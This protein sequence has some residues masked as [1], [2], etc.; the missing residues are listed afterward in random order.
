M[1]K[2]ES[3]IWVEDESKL[4][5]EENYDES[6]ALEFQKLLEDRESASSPGSL[7]SLSAGQLLTGTIVEITKD[8]VVVDVGLKSEGL[9]PSNEFASSDEIELGN[10]VE[11]YLDNTEAESGQILLSREKAR[12]QRQWEYILEK[13][14]SLKEK[15]LERS[16]VALW[17]TS[18]AWT[19][20]CLD[21][22]STTNESRQLMNTLARVSM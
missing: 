11:V 17:S 7:T 20:S 19:H 15:S 14:Q 10:Q 1:S 4:L 2:Q 8:F 3:P 13:D 6:E 22:K 18:A 21:H 12:K 5:G 16:R 9:I